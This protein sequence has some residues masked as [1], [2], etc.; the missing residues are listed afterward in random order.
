VHYSY[1]ARSAADKQDEEIYMSAGS[2]GQN[3]A[4]LYMGTKNPH[5]NTKTLFEQIP[6][7]Q[8]CSRQFMIKF[9]KA[10]SSSYSQDYELSQSLTLTDGRTAYLYSNKVCTIADDT[11]LPLYFKNLQS[12]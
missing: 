4:K 5:Q 12:Y 10:T 8:A 1:T 11:F 9:V 2:W 3:I 7:F 6:R